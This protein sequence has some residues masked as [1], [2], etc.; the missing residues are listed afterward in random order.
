MDPE[1]QEL[2]TDYRYR[3]YASVIEKA[4]RNFESSSEW[5][6]L[7]SSLGKLN[8][9]LQSNLKYSLLPRRLIISK[10]LAQCLHP[11]LPSGVHLKALETYEI[12]FKIVG[13]KW[14]AKDL[15]L[16]S[17][18]LFPLLAYAAMS[19]RPV[20]LG[21]YEKYFLP[22][23]KLLLPSLQAFLVGL[24]P[25]LEE[26]SEIYERTDTLLLRLSVVVGREVFYAAL[27]G[28]VL[29]SPSIRLPASLFVVNHISRDSPGK[30]Q[31]YMLGTDYQLTVRALCA[32]LL[33][34]NVLVQ[35]NNLEITLFFFPFYTCLDP[36]ERAI[37]LL[38]RDIVHILSAATQTLLRRDMSLNRRL[39]AWLLGSDIKGNTIVP[40][41]EISSSY[42]D[43]CSYFFDK[44][45]KDLLVEAL[46]EI[47]HQKFLNADLEERHH[48]Y[49]KPFRILVSLLDKPEIGP[50][51]VENLFLEVIRAFYSY[52]HDVLGPDL[53]L[54]YTQSGN[55]LTSTIKEN[56]HASEIVKTVNL[57][58]S[59]L[60]TDFLW[61]Y[62]ARCFEECFRVQ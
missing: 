31:K 38:R 55:L 7:I 53:R 30:E 28:S 51:V 10:R 54:S 2:L 24:L 48:E 5:A 1:E 29:T 33:D 41:S 18:G 19:V 43:Q 36:D 15:F 9:A 26:G 62:M 21:L 45:S 13:T 20:L 46:A 50:Q 40:K 12:I 60:S 42:E 23:Q 57:L 11:A 27:W 49:L 58:V 14:L 16:Y 56:R 4:L 59:S 39:Y 52:C 8:K 25:G 47:L 44:Y 3:S 32:S 35:R 37:P 61:D 34:A 17:C 22:L 6:D